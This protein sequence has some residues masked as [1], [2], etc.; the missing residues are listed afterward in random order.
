MKIDEWETIKKDLH[1]CMTDNCKLCTYYD[2]NSIDCEDCT[3]Q[4]ATEVYTLVNELE[5]T[6][7]DLIGEGK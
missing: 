7:N 2:P 1:C 6:L 5:Q 3:R 4:L